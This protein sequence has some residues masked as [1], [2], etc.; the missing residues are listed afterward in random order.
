MIWTLILAIED[1]QERSIAEEIFLTRYDL[2]CTQAYKILK[3]EAD[4]QDAVM[5]A[6]EHIIEHIHKFRGSSEN[7]DKLI[8][9]YT[10]NAAIDLYRRR[11]TQGT[12]SI[13]NPGEDENGKPFMVNYADPNADIEK[14]IINS[15][16][17]A[18]AE[19][20]M[21]QLPLAY[22]EVIYLRYFNEYSC[23]D[24]AKVL[25]VNTGTVWTRI[26]RARNALKELLQNEL[27]E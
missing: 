12:I 16:T 17:I 1:E 13:D 3:N 4:A 25:S 14:L 15:D 19:Q 18:K 7:D 5:N 21:A 11:K 26:H 24:I 10:R 2:M 27:S 6:F 8:Y 9:I 22:R 20:A 23:T